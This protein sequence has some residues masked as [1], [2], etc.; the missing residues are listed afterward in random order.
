[1]KMETSN[2]IIKMWTKET[3]QF[4]ADMD[5]SLVNDGPVTIWLDT[6]EGWGADISFADFADFRCGCAKGGF[7]NV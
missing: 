2:P 1:M 6:D 3:G 4:G 7:A 5:V